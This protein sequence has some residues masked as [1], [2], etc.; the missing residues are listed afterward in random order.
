MESTSS[1]KA[2]SLEKMPKQRNPYPAAD[3]IIYRNDKIVLVRRKEPVRGKLAFPGGFI[4]WGET[5]EA[6]AIR[7]AKEETGLDIELEELLGVYSDP[8]RDPRAHI[9]TI[10]FIGK[11]IGGK[12][13]TSEEHMEIGWYKISELD[14]SK[15]ASDHS[16]IL[17][18]FL[19]WRKQK[20]T[21]WSSK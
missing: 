21:Y 20:G 15:L 19:K 1:A 13:R 11:P 10:T 7:E 8:K 14:F 18:D 2:I 6:A 9:F 17:Q 16:K 3:V 5:V 12:L 4:E